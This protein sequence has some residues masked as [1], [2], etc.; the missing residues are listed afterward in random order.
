M[1][2]G[3][4]NPAN[5]IPWDVA[6]SIRQRVAAMSESAQII[7]RSAAIVGRTADVDLVISASELSEEHAVAALDEAAQ[8]RL[9]AWD[10]PQTIRFPHDLIREVVEADLGPARQALLHR[11]IARLVETA[12][13]EQPD[14]EDLPAELL[15]YHFERGGEPEAAIEY[16]IRSAD[17]AHRAGAHREEVA[18]LSR[19]INLTEPIWSAEATAGL[20]LDRGRAYF[21]FGLWSEARTDLEAGLAALAADDFDRRCRAL[22]DLAW[23]CHWLFDVPAT[24]RHAEEALVLARKLRRDD[25]IAESMSAA[26]FA[27]SSEGQLKASL[28]NYRSALAITPA[29]SSPRLVP[30]AEMRSL[31]LYWTGSYDE[32]IQR[33]QEALLAAQ[34]AD[35]TTYTARALGNLGMGLT[36][37]GRYTEAADVFAEARRFC[38]EHELSQWLA[39][40]VAMESGLHLAVMDYPGAENR[41]N[42]ARE[43]G[44]SIAWPLAVVSANIDLLLSFARRGEPGGQTDQLVRDAAEAAIAAT[45]AHGWLWK[46]RLAEARAEIAL[47]R[48]DAEQATAHASD[49]I[50]Q[51]RT[52]GRSKYV[53]LGLTTRAGALARLGQVREAVDDLRKAVQMA[54]STGDPSVLLQALLP[55]QSL[56][57]NDQRSAE[58]DVL[59]AQ[60]AQSL[61]GPELPGRFDAALSP[62][63]ASERASLET[64]AGGSGEGP[65]A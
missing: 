42:E 15:A 51:A 5:D 20:R 6:Q 37:R 32:S 63:G 21:D 31:I 61:P 17:F 18:L 58:I 4:G 43:I 27:E 24:Q 22:V 13:R 29:Q 38:R 26:A 53:A 25:L 64:R 9:I 28:R 19:A 59:M 62:F 57:G 7:V 2:L 14:Q 65:I 33:S 41:A 46:L 10:G 45:G 12:W 23:V 52:L 47:A 34:A 8:S 49:A 60:I 44:L 54:R 11:R 35:D 39:R 56:D 1:A 3:R 16:A 40:S 50:A 55:L 36:G 48:G 30:A